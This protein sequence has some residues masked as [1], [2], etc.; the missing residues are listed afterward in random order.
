FEST[1]LTAS[2]LRAELEPATLGRYTTCLAGMKTAPNSISHVHE[3]LGGYYYQGSLVLGGHVVYYVLTDPVVEGEFVA[4][5]TIDDPTFERDFPHAR[6]VEGDTIDVGGT[7]YVITDISV[8]VSR[9]VGS[10]TIQ[11]VEPYTLLWA[12]RDSI[13][14]KYRFIERSRRRYNPIG[15]RVG[16][17]HGFGY[18][19][20]P[21][22][23]STAVGLLAL[24]ELAYLNREHL[25]QIYDI[26][27][28]GADWLLEH[29]DVSYRGFYTWENLT[30][31]DDVFDEEEDRQR[32]FKTALA[33][34]ALLRMIGAPWEDECAGLCLTEYDARRIAIAY[35]EN[36]DDWRRCGV[37]GSIQIRE[38]WLDDSSYHITLVHA[39]TCGCN[40]PVS[41]RT[42][43]VWHIVVNA[44]CEDGLA[45]T[46]ERA[47]WE[48][49]AQTPVIPH[50][51]I[52]EHV[53]DRFVAARV[54]NEW[55]MK[56]LW[57]T[58]QPE[59]VFVA[60][61]DLAADA[62]AIAPLAAIAKEPIV[63]VEPGKIPEE[64]KRFLD[65]IRTRKAVIIGGPKAVSPAVES[66][67][68]ARGFMV[69][70]VWS[71]D[72]FGTAQQVALKYWPQ[73]SE[74]AVLVPAPFDN[75][76]IAEV[77]VAVP[78]AH[79][80]KSPL[81]LLD[82]DRIPDET[83]NALEALNVKKVILV[84]TTDLAEELANMGY[85][86]DT[87]AGK[88]KY[89]TSLVVG[90]YLEQHLNFRS[91]AFIN[92]DDP[93]AYN[94]AHLAAFKQGIV[95]LI[96]PR[97]PPKRAVYEISEEELSEIDRFVKNNK[98]KVRWIIFTGTLD[99]AQRRHLID[100]LKP[101]G[102]D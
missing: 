29:Q 8:D 36:T 51:Y 58:E 39:S 94:G 46:I 43:W 20:I 42:M 92:G 73:G 75:T 37:E 66:Q 76:T 72:R 100:L 14:D 93:G 48:C 13:L 26:M 34:M 70:R 1:Y 30:G 25:P 3:A 80:L 87:L 98:F 86:V 90:K 102:A 53:D 88:N 32:T 35:V 74:T 97:A 16:Y 33:I 15:F 60:R 82:R 19:D 23:E 22:T 9:H 6:R 95:L 59:Q 24:R 61:G 38:I 81:L 63:L 11:H 31:W 2:A 10:I 101:P 57:I 62:A 12:W 47:T 65:S 56:K 84:G 78:L 55:I 41:I 54:I 85:D 99:E 4:I 64:S 96:P 40:G 49:F 83:V 52:N 18:V 71:E 50:W 79:H 45:G 5:I 89:E 7:T 28:D 17:Y 44:S 68:A 21:D 69:E 77:L 91:I 27:L 67:L